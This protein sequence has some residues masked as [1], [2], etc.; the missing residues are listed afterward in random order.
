MVN[1]NQGSSRCQFFSLWLDPTGDS[2]PNLPHS[3]RALF[4]LGHRGG[5][6]NLKA[7]PVILLISFLL[8]LAFH[9]SKIYR[10]K[11]E[12]QPIKMF[13]CARDNYIQKISPFLICMHLI[14][15]FAHCIL[16]VLISFFILLFISGNVLNNC[17]FLRVVSYV[18]SVA[19]SS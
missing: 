4:P 13:D 17:W 2:T 6:Y 14:M 5:V 10:G 9:L 1:A 8:M 11:Y 19:M 7:I 15:F 18:D 12:K 3:E 16:S